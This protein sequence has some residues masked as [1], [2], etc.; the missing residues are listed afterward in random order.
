[1]KPKCSLRDTSVPIVKRVLNSSSIQRLQNQPR[2]HQ[3][4]FMLAAL[5]PKKGDSHLTVDFTRNLKPSLSH[6][7]EMEKRRE[8]RYSL[9]LLQNA[10]ASRLYIFKCT[11]TSWGGKRELVQG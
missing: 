6:I 9:H 11:S 1:M 3:E 10:N 7:G 2:F 5:Y 8:K 4:Y